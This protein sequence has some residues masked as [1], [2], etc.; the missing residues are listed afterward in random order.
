[1]FESASGYIPLIPN[2][3][4]YWYNTLAE[5]RAIVETRY[6]VF[7]WDG[8][9]IANRKNIAEQYDY[10]HDPAHEPCT[11][12]ELICF[13]DELKGWIEKARQESKDAAALAL[14]DVADR[15]DKILEDDRK[16]VGAEIQALRATVNAPVLSDKTRDSTYLNI[17]GALLECIF[18][19]A[20]TVKKTPIIREPNGAGY[21]LERKTH[22]H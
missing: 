17:I 22:R 6:F 21:A 3:E 9:D 18:G 4:N 8:L 10:Q 19:N 5:M 20:P 13:A 7:P 16:R 11:Y 12:F 15:L 14:R 1:M 2:L